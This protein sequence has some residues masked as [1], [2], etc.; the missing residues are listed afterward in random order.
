MASPTVH[1]VM[2]AANIT[3]DATGVPARQ[4]VRSVPEKTEER[5]Y[6]MRYAQVL[7]V[8]LVMGTLA[9]FCAAQ[10]AKEPSE[11][12]AARAAYQK[13]VDR[14]RTESERQLSLAIQG[15][16]DKYR[17]RL[18][19]IKDQYD[20]QRNTEA[21]FA[22]LQEMKIL[23]PNRPAPTLIIWNEHNGQYNNA[24]TLKCNVGLYKGSNKKPFWATN[25]L[26]L[27]WEPN[28]DL[29]TS[30]ELP[31]TA[32][33][34]IRVEVTQWKDVCG[35]LAEIEILDGERNLAR[36]AKVS[37]SAAVYPA[38]AP[39]R[40]VDGITSSK[41]FEQGYWQLPERTPGWIELEL[42]PNTASHSTAL[43]RRP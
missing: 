26:A 30:L 38:Y 42:R 7:T 4:R 6:A 37:A 18:R 36:N 19:F 35:G 32:F 33:D 2:N 27:V 5:W 3:P 40:I 25:D 14:L 39:D 11:L 28:G 16:I 20:S 22:V 8:G 1:S 9:T 34:R 43:P 31:R 10:V 15:E 24:G 12:T 23:D 29:K 21:A 41:T 17:T 13:E